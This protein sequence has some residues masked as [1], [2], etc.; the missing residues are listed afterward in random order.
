MMQCPKCK[1]RTV[2]P[3]LYGKQSVRMQE[4]AAEGKAIIIPRKAVEGEPNIGC[5]RC[6]FMWRPAR[7]PAEYM[8]NLSWNI[9]KK[10]EYQTIVKD[11]IELKKDGTV[12]YKRYIGDARKASV[13]IRGGIPREDAERIY[14]EVAQINLKDEPENVYDN[15]YVTMG[16]EDGYSSGTC[17][18]AAVDLA[19]VITDEI[20]EIARAM[21]VFVAKEEADAVNASLHEIRMRERQKEPAPDMSDSDKFFLKTRRSDAKGIETENGFIVL[22]GSR[23]SDKEAPSCQATIRRM[24]S[25]AIANGF[26][27]EWVLTKDMHFKGKSPACAFVTG[28]SGDGNRWKG[29]F[30]LYPELSEDSVLFRNLT[31]EERAAYDFLMEDEQYNSFPSD[32]FSEHTVEEINDILKSCGITVTENVRRLME[33]EI[34]NRDYFDDMLRLYDE[35]RKRNGQ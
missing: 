26:V 31:K 6:G 20:P 28:C 33:L 25:E 18:V 22:A 1:M 9:E 16:F 12:F 3:V 7:L 11:R 21:T 14:A 34:E 27:K 23:I 10:A 29:F 17:D 5:A 8:K 19:N 15:A 30:D 2:V 4:K 13:N 35:M 32:F 24:R